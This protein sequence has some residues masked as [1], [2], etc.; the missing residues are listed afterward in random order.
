MISSIS[1]VFR[2]SSI[3][4]LEFNLA[5]SSSAPTGRFRM[6]LASLRFLKSLLGSVFT[7]IGASS[8]MSS[9]LLTISGPSGISGVDARVLETNSPVA[10]ASGSK[11]D[12]VVTRITFLPF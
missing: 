10:P 12:S 7:S 1:I 8:S 6:F 11:L 5:S 4:L 2:S 3:S 9:S